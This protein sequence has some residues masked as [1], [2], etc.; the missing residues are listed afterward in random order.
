MTDGTTGADDGIE[1]C[2]CFFQLDKSFLQR[3]NV[4]DCSDLLS[5]CDVFP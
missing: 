5:A 3:V 4:N 1:E 2:P